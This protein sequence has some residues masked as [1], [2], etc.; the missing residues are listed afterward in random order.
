MKYGY[1]FCAVAALA[2]LLRVS[3]VAAMSYYVS[4]TGS[5]SNSGTSTS[6]PFQTVP[7]AA[8]KTHPGDV[9]YVMNGSY[10]PFMISRSGSASGGYITYQA[11]PGQHPTINKTGQIWDAIQLQ[12]TV[13]PSY[14][15][16]DGFNIVGD[17]Q[18]ITLNQ[19]LSAPD[20]NNTTNGNCI[21]AGFGSSHIIIRNNNISYCPGGGIA[22]F[23]DYIQ[24]YWN[25]IHHNSYWSPF[26]TSGITVVGKDS[27][28][29]T[30][31]KILVFNNILYNNQ[32]FV[33]N[34]FQTNPCQITDGEGII[35]D[36]NKD[37][38][39]KGR[40]EVYNNIT[41]NNGGPGIAIHR[42][43]HA[44]VVNNTAYMNDISAAEPA[45]FTAHTSGGEIAVTG[46]SD[47]NVINNI[48]YGSP[49]VPVTEVGS[50]TQLNWDYSI[51]FGGTNAKPIGSHDLV[52]DPLFIDGA[53][54]NFHLQTGSP[55][56]GSGTSYLAPSQDFDGT[57]RP[58][59]S[60]CR[61][62]YQF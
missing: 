37:Y 28:S 36:S 61:G 9:V 26:D 42:S 49:N 1:A 34:K 57:S 48:V 59:G 2:A 39:Y 4:P 24:I 12:A 21:G 32:N 16:I 5:D 11:Y 18:S 10:G 33:C 55:A 51:L 44:D 25:V 56:I 62:V 45:P 52:E 19:A 29:N 14:I 27:D 13:G 35:V 30:G 22:V 20:Y 50:D 53:S 15:I 7:K 58:K 17:A 6:S 23:G 31:P 3:N 54:F 40:V 60:I 43:Q 46:S 8:A 41:Y 38:S 47:V